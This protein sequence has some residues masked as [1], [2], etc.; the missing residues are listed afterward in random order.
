MRID[1]VRPPWLTELPQPYHRSAPWGLTEV[2][3]RFV[4]VVRAASEL[5]VCLVC[6]PAFCE[7]DDV[8]VL[9]EASL[10]APAM[11]PH[12]CTSAAVA[13]PDRAPH[14]RPDVAAARLCRS[15]LWPAWTRNASSLALLEVFDQHC[16]GPV[17]DDGRVAVGD[18]VAKQVA[19][20]AEPGV[21]LGTDGYA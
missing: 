8:V 2:A 10:V 6:C 9:E 1:I 4:C 17:E 5:E 15:P 13:G 7:R 16:E 14:R 21:G 20:P 19:G 3:R 11:R 18:G 12:E